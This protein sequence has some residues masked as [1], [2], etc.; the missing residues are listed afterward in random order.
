MYGWFIPAFL[1]QIVE[2]LRDSFESDIDLSLSI[3]N[4]FAECE[5]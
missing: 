5:V 1:R 4:D 3:S 2:K